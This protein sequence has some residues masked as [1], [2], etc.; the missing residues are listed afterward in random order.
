MRDPFDVPLEDDELLEEL[1][2]TTELIIAAN[3]TAGPLCHD[4]LDRI[5]L[6]STPE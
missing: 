4:R 2:L 3:T 5:L 1:R 6:R